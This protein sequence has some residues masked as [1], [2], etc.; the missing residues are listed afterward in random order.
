MS[1]AILKALM[2]LFALISD[3]HDDTVITAREKNI[4]RIF[5][6]RHVNNELVDKYMTM[7]E[8]YLGMFNSDRIVKGSLKDRKRISLNAMRILAIC[9]TINAELQQKQKVYVVVKLTDYI[10]SGAELSETELDF[11]QTVSVAFNIPANEFGNIRNFIISD[12]TEG[13]EQSEVLTIE[14]APEKSIE[15][16]RI[17]NENL[18][19]K[20]SILRIRST[21]T[22][23]MRYHGKEAL[24]LNGQ[25]ISEGETYIFDSGS[26][27]RG[28]GI[29]AIYYSEIIGYLTTASRSEGIFLDVSDVTFNFRN[30]GNGIHNLNF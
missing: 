29:K 23:L 21:N 13:C 20:I 19:G 26:S 7:F 28:S 18:K 2:Q 12:D 11:L 16:K 17:C 22:F 5:L 1:E 9:E 30:S 27:I 14:S 10:A 8:E 3:M 4:V 6:I 25:N 24:Y 15:V